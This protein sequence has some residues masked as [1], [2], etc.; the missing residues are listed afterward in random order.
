MVSVDGSE[1]TLSLYGDDRDA[2][3]VYGGALEADA[4]VAWAIK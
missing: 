4:V 1:E 2:P 3:V